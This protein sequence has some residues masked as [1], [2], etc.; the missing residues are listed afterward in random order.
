MY[1]P[2]HQRRFCSAS[3]CY[4]ALTSYQ[5]ARKIEGFAR[6]DDTWEA[7]RISKPIP[8]PCFQTSGWRVQGC[9][10]THKNI[11]APQNFD[12]ASHRR[13]LERS[14]EISTAVRE[15]AC[16]RHF[17]NDVF[18]LRLSAISQIPSHSFLLS[19]FKVSLLNRFA[20]HAIMS[21]S[22]IYIFIDIVIYKEDPHDH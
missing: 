13:H 10:A 18:V 5:C 16:M 8:N 4:L 22:S 19:N 17:I 15:S 12:D 21:T 7:V 3:F 9:G 20:P 2:F 11:E 14:R 6:A 1:A